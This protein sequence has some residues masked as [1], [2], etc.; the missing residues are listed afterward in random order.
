MPLHI[1]SLI[2]NTCNNEQ[3]DI[4]LLLIKGH[5]SYFFIFFI[6]LI[7]TNLL[8][9]F[10]SACMCR[11][12]SVVCSFGYPCVCMCVGVG[13]YICVRMP[14]I[15]LRLCSSGPVHLAYETEFQVGLELAEQARLV[16]Y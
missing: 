3:A 4:H 15:K 9:K 8:F 2:H 1:V 12:I 5:I 11:C 13:V 14:E 6:F 10:R 7:F 16:G